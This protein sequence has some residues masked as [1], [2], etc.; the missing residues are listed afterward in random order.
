MTEFVGLR[1]DEIVRRITDAVREKLRVNEDGHAPGNDRRAM[2]LRV[3]LDD[4][5]PIELLPLPSRL[6]RALRC[7]GVDTLGDLNGV[8]EADIGRW[9]GIGRTSLDQ[10]RKFLAL[11][12]RSLQP[13]ALATKG[14]AH[15]ESNASA[16]KASTRE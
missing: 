2:G 12:G 13:A 4:G 5:T 6:I 8:S 15:P 16:G 1:S 7:A 10:L 9:R 3:E 14:N 11:A